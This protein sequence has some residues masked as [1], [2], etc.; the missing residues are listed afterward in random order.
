MWRMVRQYLHASSDP[1][2]NLEYFIQHMLPY[3]IYHMTWSISWTISYVIIEHW[4]ILTQFCWIKTRLRWFWSE[5]KYIP[6]SF[7]TWTAMMGPPYELW[8]FTTSG[9]SRLMNCFAAF[10]R[11]LSPWTDRWEVLSAVSVSSFLRI[12]MILTSHYHIW[13]SQQPEGKSAPVP[14]RTNIWSGT[15]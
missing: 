14:L 15:K 9:S 13:I 11:T 6:Y 4:I 5:L 1:E 10:Q 12:S 2:A 8:R 3:Y 7:S